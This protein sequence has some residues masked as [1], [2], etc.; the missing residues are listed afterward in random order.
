M[1]IEK[2]TE[3][4]EQEKVNMKEDEHKKVKVNRKLISGSLNSIERKKFKS[5]E[6]YEWR[7]S[8]DDPIPKYTYHII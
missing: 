7:E 1:W 3:E 5:S 6:E 2:K 4:H 8:K